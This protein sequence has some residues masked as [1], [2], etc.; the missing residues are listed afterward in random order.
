MPTWVCAMAGIYG[1]G[2]QESAYLNM[3]TRHCISGCGGVKQPCHARLL[4]PRPSGTPL[5]GG[6]AGIYGCGIHGSAH[7]N[8]KTRHCISGWVGSS[9]HVMTMRVGAMAGIYGC[10]IQESAHLNM[11][12]RHCIS[13]WGR[14]KQPC[15]ADEG[16]CDGG[17][18]WRR[19]SQYENPILWWNRS[20]LGVLGLTDCQRLRSAGGVMEVLPCGKELRC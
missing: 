17:H 1:C 16:L 15:H 8:I 12:T 13:G 5:K 6:M 20:F 14:V 18:L 11:K 7:F 2:I 4:I 19:P 3:K 9:S 10:D